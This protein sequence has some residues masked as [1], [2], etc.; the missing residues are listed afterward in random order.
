MNMRKILYIWMS[1]MTIAG[2][3]GCSDDDTKGP[4]ISFRRAYYVLSAIEML[5]VEVRLSEPAK[6]DLTVTF[7]VGGTG[8]EGTDYAISAH[9][10]VV[11]AGLDS[12][13]VTIT[14]LNN[15]NEGRE[16]YLALRKAEGYEFGV[17]K[18]TVIPIERKSA[19][20]TYFFPTEYNLY[21]EMEVA[22][23]LD[24][25]SKEYTTP[26]YDIT[27][28]FEVDPA[29]TAVLGTHFEIVG[30]KQ[31]FL[32]QKDDY[33]GR[34]KLKFLKK[35]EGK[36]KIVLRL[37]ETDNFMISTSSNRAYITINGPVGFEDLLGSWK[38]EEFASMEYVKSIAS[39][40]GDTEGIKNLPESFSS[41]ILVFETS[42]GKNVIR[43][44]QLNGDLKNYL[45]DGSEIVV[46]EIVN[47]QIY[48]PDEVKEWGLYRSVL[49][50]T[51][52]KVNL[53]FSAT[54]QSYAPAEVDFRVLGDGDI[55]ELRI[56]QY[57]PTDFLQ[58]TYEYYSDPFY[59]GDINFD[60][61]LPMKGKYTLSFRFSKVD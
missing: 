20:T 47:E 11:K 48:L 49:R 9:E 26:P 45:C 33:M 55:L 60:K 57:V 52:S 4:N 17:Y 25:G 21:K 28:P 61:N 6:E 42:G 34:V 38:F 3:G 10:F 18:Q 7:E 24:I 14:P 40:A 37:V 59:S 31:Q 54:H 39:M 23:R 56:V 16:I 51:F 22:T 46:G 13:V 12:A 15:V 32:Y 8:E 35:E 19:F 44:G 58:E 43:T 29:S 41:D 30:Q 27:I 1:I 50:T 36:D 5:N 2:M 53:S